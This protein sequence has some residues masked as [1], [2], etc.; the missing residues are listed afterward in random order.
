[1]P[2]LHPPPSPVPSSRTPPPPPNQT[3]TTS[4]SLRGPSSSTPVISAEAIS[5]PGLRKRRR[6]AIAGDLP[7][8]ILPPKETL[9]EATTGP[10]APA[11]ADSL[12]S[13]PPLPFV[14]SA[15]NN[16]AAQP[17]PVGDGTYTPEALLDEITQGLPGLKDP[18]DFRQFSGYLPISDSKNIF[19]WYVEAV[20][21]PDTAPLVFWTN[22]GP[23]CSGLYGFLSE[24]GPWRPLKDGATLV[25][26]AYSWNQV[27][28]MLYVEQPVTVGF[29]YTTEDLDN[30]A[31]F[32]DDQAASDNYRV[33][34]AFLDRFP[35]LRAHD[36]YLSG[37]SYSGHYLPSLA[38][39]ILDQ[40]QEASA[41]VAAA[42]AASAAG[43]ADAFPPSPPPSTNQEMSAQALAVA[44]PAA[45]AFPLSPPS[46]EQ[47]SP[48]PLPPSLPPPPKLNLRGFLVGNPSTDPVLQLIGQVDTLHSRHLLPPSLYERWTT[49][50][51]STPTVAHLGSTA[52]VQVQRQVL[53]AVSEYDVYSISTPPCPLLAAGEEEENIGSSSSSSSS[54]SGRRSKSTTAPATAPTGK[55]GGKGG[56]GRLYLLANDEYWAG[57][58]KLEQGNT[59]AAAAVTAAAVGCNSSSTAPGP[60]HHHRY[61]RS[62]SPSPSPSPPT[63]KPPSLFPSF[64]TS[65]PLPYESCQALYG[66]NYLNRLDVKAAIHASE[67]VSWEDCSSL[68]LDN[69]QRSDWSLYMEP[70]F[71]SLLEGGKEGEAGREGG[72][73]PLR[74][75]LYSGEDDT[76]CSSKGTEM[77]L[78]TLGWT[79]V[80]EWAPW[81]V[82]EGG[83]E[84]GRKGIGNGK[85]GVLA[86]AGM[87]KKYE[88]GV[89][90]ATVN[91]AG[92]AVPSFKPRE[93][94]YLFQEFLEGRL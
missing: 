52:C 94:L 54:S 65:P 44:A 86:V 5:P 93:A 46:K 1:M 15:N 90:F 48:Q 74:V 64:P 22:G 33:I 25:R 26:N 43:S 75:L 70:T 17:E 24:H 68:V 56:G 19:Y 47:T 62:S 84:G 51:A 87:K 18:I 11:A 85:V 9:A 40:N 4:S 66:A 32:G 28:N 37:E 83:K 39:F 71:K 30:K 13:P 31:A 61:L 57:L 8:I 79:T 80:E 55:K 12:A 16:T 41:S 50:C 67:W 73:E 81:S 29:S 53:E 78:E 92:H 88:N 60:L 91:G 72:G 35:H 34:Q 77:W 69:F 27:A 6:K 23:G 45:A 20:H 10:A 76:V 89:V 49:L 3:A 2:D 14:P 42:A 7:P 63:S 82:K 58:L 36:L 21:N 38:R 59:S